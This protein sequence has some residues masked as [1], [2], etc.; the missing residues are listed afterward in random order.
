MPRK[1]N[2]SG[3]HYNDPFPTVL[4]ELIEENGTRQDELKEV[5]EVKN[6]QS[7]TGYVDGSTI[8]TIDKAKALA[9]FFHVSVDYMLTG[10][11][12]LRPEEPDKRAIC[13]YTGLSEE[14][15]DFLHESAT[16]ETVPDMTNLLLSY[17]ADT[18]REVSRTLIQAASCSSIAN[19]HPDAD[20]HPAMPF[21]YEMCDKRP[22]SLSEIDDTLPFR[23]GI[24]PL[25]ARDASSFYKEKAS[26]KMWEFIE[27]SVDLIVEAK[28]MSKKELLKNG[29]HKE[30]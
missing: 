8:P 25:S 5:L 28:A 30:D 14:S 17:F 16:D 3:E 2:T 7:V 21:I 26:R 11:P 27:G 9:E 19:A 4:R 13:D 10:N 23:P 24:V 15:I 22:E 18:W 20:V 1:Q 12:C 6:R 29:E